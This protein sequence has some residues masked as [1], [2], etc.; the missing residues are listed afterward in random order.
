MAKQG[1]VP[2]F[3]PWLK[4]RRLAAKISLRAFALK[5]GV[6]AGNLS[7][8]ERSVLPPP[9]DL[10]TLRAFARVLGID[11]SSRAWHR[12]LD[13]ASVEAAKIP[14]D[15]AKSPD[16][17]A[18]LPLLFRVARGAELTDDELRSLAELV[19]KS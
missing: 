6:D 1:P 12:M 7:K 3:G 18:R 19:E 4:E 8:Y 14:P 11:K 17:L 16:A 15:L 2:R 13:L 10:R 5:T 9:T